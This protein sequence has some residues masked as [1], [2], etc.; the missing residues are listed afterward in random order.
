MVVLFNWFRLILRYLIPAQILQG[1]LPSQELLNRYQSL[2]IYAILAKA[3]RKGNLDLFDKMFSEHQA[4]L[5]EWGTWLIVER[6]RLLVV[7]QL[8]KKIWG[9]LEKP[10]R[11]GIDVLQRGLAISA[12]DKNLSTDDVS[13]LIVNL[14]DKGYMKGYVSFEKQ[15]LVL[16]NSDPFPKME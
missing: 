14:I 8:F 13:C 9:M 7:R 11:L 4:T 15:V 5:I 16:S 10:S 3:I 12:N 2:K 6:T 1:S